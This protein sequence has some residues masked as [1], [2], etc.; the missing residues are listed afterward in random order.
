MLV[1]VV[2]LSAL[3]ASET[4]KCP[5]P[6]RCE[7]IDQV[8]N[9]SDT[10][11]KQ[12]PKI[13]GERSDYEM[14]LIERNQLSI[15]KND[16]LI[17]FSNLLLLSVADNNISKVENISLRQLNQ[18]NRIDLSKNN[19]SA[20]P[21]AILHLSTLLELDLGDNVISSVRQNDIRGL[22]LLEKLFLDGNN[23]QHVPDAFLEHTPDLKVFSLAG[24]RLESIGSRVFRCAESLR[25]LYLSENSLRDLPNGWLTGASNLSI[26][27]M[28]RAMHIINDPD[29]DVQAYTFPGVAPDLETLILSG[30]GI[31]ELKP[32]AFSPLQGLKQLDLSQ[33]ILRYLPKGCFSPNLALEYVNLRSNMIVAFQ[34]QLFSDDTGVR[35]SEINLENNQIEN[36]TKEGFANMH[37][38]KILNLGGN[39]ILQIDSMVFSQLRLLKVLYLYNN[40]ITNITYYSFSYLFSIE[41]IHIQ[42]NRLPLVPNVANLTRLQVLDVSRNEISY[43]HPEAFQGTDIQK[44][45]LNGNNL[46][47]VPQTIGDLEL[48]A[49]KVSN[50]PW[51]CGCEISWMPKTGR[52]TPQSDLKESE[53]RWPIGMQG[54]TLADDG[55]DGLKCSGTITPTSIVILVSLWLTVLLILVLSVILRQYHKFR[56]KKR[57]RGDKPSKD[58]D[59]NNYKGGENY[60]SQEGAELEVKSSNGRLNGMKIKP[61]EEEFYV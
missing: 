6:C 18:L 44:L 33:N 27:D 43:I 30:N 60:Y 20:I 17:G 25:E 34:T 38:L 35:M 50:N 10:S 28:T 19:I 42:N 23:I 55:L 52:Q 15:I 12:I 40:V 26:L 2:F 1:T 49:L 57:R 48:T 36:I 56:V 59:N 22:N 9:C 11:L 37:N 46:K 4:S 8:L 24:N 3:T 7:P 16:S 29:V 51:H 54:R 31:R 47:T 32:L 61:F 21:T 39:N 58:S 53:C 45:Y 5:K 13:L 41:E 14:F